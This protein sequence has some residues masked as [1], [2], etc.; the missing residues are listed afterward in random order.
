M[1]RLVLLAIV[2]LLL[3]GAYYVFLAKN[4][5]VGSKEVLI[6]IPKG[7]GIGSVTDSLDAHGLLRSTWMFRM[8][9]RTMGASKKL[10]AGLYRIQPGLSNAQIVKRLTGSEYALILQATF[11][12]GITIYRAASIAKEKLGLD[13]GIFMRYATDTGFFH[14]F[15]VPKEAKTAE[16]YAFPDTYEFVLSADPKELLTRM[17][18]RW[19]KI[20]YDSLYAKSPHGNLSLHQFMTL[21]SIVEAEAKRP[22]ERDTI[23][24]VYL[25]R[26]KVGMKLDAD[27]SVQYG[28]HL[29]RPITHEDLLTQNPYNTYMNVGLP[30]GPICN[31]GAA[32]IRAVLNPAKHNFIYFVARRDGSGGHYFSKSLSEQEQKINIA[33]ANAANP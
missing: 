12:E 30:P 10:H 26:L 29:T 22:E 27:P 7:A 5:G 32:S 31:P 13:S 8:A 16:G 6:S 3:F 21:A 9:A 11:P 23:A 20:G 4:P 2:A 14:P 18:R 1:K 17:L 24:G 33:R 19:K 15:G 28:L 25:N